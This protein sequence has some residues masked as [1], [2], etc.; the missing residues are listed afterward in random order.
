MKSFLRK[1]WLLWATPLIVVPLVV[2]AVAYLA[3]AEA[4][5]PDSPF[6]YDL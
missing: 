3:R 1:H 6:I 4:T 5:T 2:A